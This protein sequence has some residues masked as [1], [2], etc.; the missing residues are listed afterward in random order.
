MPARNLSARESASRGV[1]NLAR[2]RH[3][4]EIKIKEPKTGE[5]Y[6]RR[7]AG[8]SEE[9]RKGRARVEAR[10]TFGK[11]QGEGGQEGAQGGREGRE[12]IA[13]AGAARPAKAELPTH[14]H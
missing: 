10:G 14:P 4:E 7:S 1:P 3:E 9:R 6:D 11:V 8:S 2:E 5:S 13:E 12:E